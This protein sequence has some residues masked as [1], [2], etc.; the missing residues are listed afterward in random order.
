MTHSDTIHSRQSSKLTPRRH[1]TASTAARSILRWGT[2][3]PK[4]LTTLAL[5]AL[6]TPI[7][8]S[9]GD[10]GFNGRSDARYAVVSMSMTQTGDW[11]VPQYMGKIH[12]TKPPLVYWAES[13]S[14][15]LLG[16]TLLAVRLPSAIAGSLTLLLLFFFARS[17][18][19]LR[20]ALITTGLYAIMPLTIIPARMTVTDSTVN[21]CWAAVLFTG[22]LSRQHPEQ[23]RWKILF[24][25]AAAIGML[26]KGPVLF[27]P[28]GLVGL[29]WFLS[30]SRAIR[31][32]PTAAFF[33]CLLL[34]MLPTLAWAAAVCIAQPAAVQIWW[35][36]TFDRVVGQGDHT[37]PIWFF[38]PILF[39]GCFPASAMLMLPGYNLSW[40]QALQNITSGSLV[41]FLGWAVLI[42]F[43]VF[44]LFSG[45]LPSYIMPICA[46]LALLSAI[47]LE[48]WFNNKK[49][50]A[51][52]RRAP[53][54]RYGLCI[55]TLIFATA[56]TTVILLT[57]GPSAL[58]WVAPLSIPVIASLA[59]VFVWK[60][61]HQ[62]L[63]AL[64]IFIAAWLVGWLGLEE[65]EDVTLAQMSYLGIAQETF[66]GKGWTGRTAAYR[67]DDGIIAWDNANHLEHYETPAQI[68]NALENSPAEPILVLT[69][70]EQWDKL[71]TTSPQL[72]T[73]GKITA[74]WHQWPGAPARYLVVIDPANA[75]SAQP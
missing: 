71:A 74:D 37:R 45:K 38:I 6:L 51:E 18:L 21:L 53:E 12:L 33:G 2:Q 44:S 50:A 63:P 49:P 11:L 29:W 14:M 55:G 65:L 19:R 1:S 70:A 42:P 67:L 52:G 13:L 36:E 73:M 56:T 25:T 10:H 48:S 5:L 23:H 41:G 4:L 39:A 57:Y 15:R 61:R 17:Q 28:I 20:T 7:W 24:W 35:H 22:F 46:P 68:K 9:I 62:R 40:R 27:I 26:A 3:H 60:T 30:N 32:K 31:I 64:A 43:L 72:H 69:T 59:L 75:P 58:A 66:G 34:A 16:D 54:T 8:V 47:M